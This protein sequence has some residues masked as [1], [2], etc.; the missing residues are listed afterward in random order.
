MG[1]TDGKQMVT[2]IDKWRATAVNISGV[3]VNYF[4]FGVI[5]FAMLPAPGIWR[6]TVSLLDVM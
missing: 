1:Q 5:V 2:F 3:T 6:K 4:L